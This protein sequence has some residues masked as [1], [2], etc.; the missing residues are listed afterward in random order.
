M[1]YY[2]ERVLPITDL[3]F[4]GLTVPYYLSPYVYAG[5]QYENLAHYLF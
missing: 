5:I 4:N 2:S 1:N 3:E